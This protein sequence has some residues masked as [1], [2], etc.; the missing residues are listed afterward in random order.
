M[1]KFALLFALVFTGLIGNVNAE[2]PT[3]VTLTQTGCQFLEPE[4]R[5]HGYTTHSADDCEATNGLT[6]QQRL[7]Q[8]RPIKL[9]P[10]MYVFRVTNKNVPYTLGFWLRGVGLGRL[11]LPSVSGGGIERGKSIDYAITLGPGEYRYSCPLN[12]TPDYVLLVE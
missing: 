10:G 8:S 9:K 1:D 3:L 2:Q 7:A 4:Q 11:T 12:P 6:A 5:D